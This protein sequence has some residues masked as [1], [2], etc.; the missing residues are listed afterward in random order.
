MNISSK[1]FWQLDAHVIEVVPLI[2]DYGV[3]V[4]KVDGKMTF[5]YSVVRVI[6]TS[7]L[8]CEKGRTKFFSLQGR[9][10]NLDS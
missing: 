2:D 8:R 3:K 4:V 10:K 7:I 1:S 5:Y 9:E 6:D